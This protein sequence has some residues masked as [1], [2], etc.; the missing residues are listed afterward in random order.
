MRHSRYSRTSEVVL[1]DDEAG[2]FWYAKN[3]G[4]FQKEEKLGIY[5]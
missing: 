3:L 5:G 2:L 1:V 4:R